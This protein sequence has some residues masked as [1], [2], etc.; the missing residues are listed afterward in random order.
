MNKLANRDI[1]MEILALEVLRGVP[2]ELTTI[3]KEMEER[4]E[5]SEW[6]S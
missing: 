2:Y 4:D 3:Y 6:P 5:I 1:L